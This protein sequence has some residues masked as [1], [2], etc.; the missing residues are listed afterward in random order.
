[1]DAQNNHSAEA[2]AAA[3]EAELGQL[4]QE[5]E[6]LKANYHAALDA[7][8]AGLDLVVEVNRAGRAT[9]AVVHFAQMIAAATPEPHAVVE[10]H[11]RWA[12]H[13]TRAALD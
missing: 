3:T 9:H 6:R 4:R 5:L 7:L 11:I 12:L 2:R 8:E 1:M 10:A 13:M